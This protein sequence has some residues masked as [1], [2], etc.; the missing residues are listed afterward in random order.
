M[1]KN[2]PVEKIREAYEAGAK[3]FGENRV[4]E[5]LTK[6]SELPRDI[7]WHFVGS[8][9]TN[10]VRTLLDVEADLVS[11][12][13]S[14][15]QPPR[16]RRVHLWRK[17]LPL[18]LHSLDR[19]PLA[20]EIEKQ[21]EKKNLRVEALIQVNTTGEA[22]KSGFV[23]EDVE[24]GVKAI[25]QMNRIQLRGLMTIG[26]TPSAPPRNNRD[27]AIFLE[28][29]TVPDFSSRDSFRRL[30]LLRDELQ[31]KFPDLDLRQLS[32]GMSSDFEIAIEEG[33]TLVRIGTAV[34]GER[35]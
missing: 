28:N 7:R 21:A 26:P 16:Q 8:L 34:F 5:L 9:Q 25:A 11:A 35:K 22:A 18:L 10:K 29:R 14:Q 32:M 19:V 31:E 17:G 2:V 15:G 27:G 20:E 12:R 33:A 4:Q 24:A 3:D 13:L 23:A 1:T 30:R 6:K